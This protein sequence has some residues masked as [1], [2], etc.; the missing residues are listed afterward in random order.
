MQTKHH[1]GCFK[2]CAYEYLGQGTMRPHFCKGS[3]E[4]TLDTSKHFSCVFCRSVYRP[5]FHQ[6]RDHQL[7]LPVLCVC[8]CSLFAAARSCAKLRTALS[9]NHPY[10]LQMMLDQDSRLACTSRPKSAQGYAFVETGWSSAEPFFHPR[11]IGQGAHTCSCLVGV[12]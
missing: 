7:L 2:S 4:L 3:P 6:R 9:A 11:T 1:L 8:H 10:I 12:P 5:N